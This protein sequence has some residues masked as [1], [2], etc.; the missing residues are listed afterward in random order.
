MDFT[1]V[2]KYLQDWNIKINASRLLAWLRRAFSK[3]PEIQ[4]GVYAHEVI[5]YQY[6]CV[7]SCILKGPAMFKPLYYSS[8]LVSSR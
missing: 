8:E 3:M 4:Y 2:E 1:T 7:Y 6:C 5:S